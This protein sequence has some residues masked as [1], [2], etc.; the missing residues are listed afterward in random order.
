M[1]ITMAMKVD[2]KKP[3]AKSDDHYDQMAADSTIPEF[4]EGT[5]YD[6]EMILPV[7]QQYTPI[8]LTAGG[9]NAAQN[10]VNLVKN[11]N[12]D[13]IN[14]RWRPMV[15][16]QYLLVCVCDFVIFPVLWSLLQ[17]ISKGQV[18]S[19][20]QPLTLQGAGLYHLAMGAVMGI[21]SYGRTK[22]KIEGK[23]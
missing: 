8:N 7:S 21:T 17:A 1:S 22:E 20:Y 15:S 6:S 19:Q 14:R 5:K 13:W 2:N 4:K 9:D 11:D 23:E 12:T 16:W 3:M 18:T 10:A